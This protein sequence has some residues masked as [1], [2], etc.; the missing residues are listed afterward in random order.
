MS[1]YTLEFKYTKKHIFLIS[2]NKDILLLPLIIICMVA[3]LGGPK[4]DHNPIA[5]GHVQ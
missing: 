4:R 2:L 5:S 1:Q 3:T